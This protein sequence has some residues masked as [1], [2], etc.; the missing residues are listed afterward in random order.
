MHIEITVLVG[1]KI[2]HSD[3][4]VVWE[5]P[6]ISTINTSYSMIDSTAITEIERIRLLYR[7]LGEVKFLVADTLELL[8]HQ[9]LKHRTKSTDGT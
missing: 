5:R 1:N 7:I 8:V 9:Y 2:T 3:G 4:T 6:Q